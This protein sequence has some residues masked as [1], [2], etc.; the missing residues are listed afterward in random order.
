MGV[1]THGDLA[2]ALSELAFSEEWKEEIAEVLDVERP[3]DP[4]CRRP[5]GPDP[6]VPIRVR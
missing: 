6:T 4:D 3:D 1:D 5:H 2:K